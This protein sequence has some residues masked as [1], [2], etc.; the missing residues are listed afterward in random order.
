MMVFKFF[1]YILHPIFLA[2]QY[3][4]IFQPFSMRRN[5]RSGL[6]A[7]SNKLCLEMIFP[8][9]VKNGICLPKRHFHLCFEDNNFNK[10]QTHFI[11]S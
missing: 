8:I 2:I 10:E 1:H 4:H 11:L 7:K 6:H 9:N 3:V 5:W